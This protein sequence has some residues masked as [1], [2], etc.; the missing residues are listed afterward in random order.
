MAHFELRPRAASVPVR[1]RTVDEI[2]YFITG[3]GQMWRR[4]DEAETVEDVRAGTAIT[5]PVG[6]S[7]QF[8]STSD[9]PLAAIG[10]TMPPWPGSGEG[11]CRNNG[12]AKIPVVTGSDRCS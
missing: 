3:H 7:F 12:S 9:D 4:Q 2:W 1:H 5:I 11:A 6:T 10:V 8:R